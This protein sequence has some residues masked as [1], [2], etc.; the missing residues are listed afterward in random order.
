[1]RSE[2]PAGPPVIFAHRGLNRVAP[3]NTLP[4]FHA[5]ADAG[6]EWM[7]TDVDLSAD[8]V[9][10]IMHDSTLHRTTN[11]QGRLNAHSWEELRRADAG[12]WFSP[13]Y[14]GTRLPTLTQL[15]DLVNQRGLNL[16][17]E[18]KPHESGKAGT[19]SLIETVIAELGR[20]HPERGVIVSSFSPLTLYHFHERAPLYPL[21]MLWEDATLGPDWKSVLEMVGATHAHIEDRSAT[22][23][24]VGDLRE[25][26]FGV[27][28]W[29][30][31]DPQRAQDLFRWGCTGVF[32]DVA[33][34][35]QAQDPTRQRG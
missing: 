2:S 34:V 33:D 31:N 17:L 10:V 4:A 27:N 22:P 14:A 20:L 26:G 19:V 8:G 6:V 7:E 23:E 13:E 29:T 32:S 12:S 25:A 35:L 1:M 3:E 18:L 5:A 30:V 24:V 16:N 9:P 15:V 11:L 28:V 21:G